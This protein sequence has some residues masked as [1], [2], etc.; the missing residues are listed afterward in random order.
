MIASSSVA[1]LTNGVVGPAVRSGSV[2]GK[3]VAFT[4]DGRDDG[5]KPVGDGQYRI[6]VWA[7]DV[8]NNRASIAK[9]VISESRAF[10]EIGRFYLKEVIGRGIPMF[11][12]TAARAS[13]PAPS[14][15]RQFLSRAFH[16]GSDQRFYDALDGN[17]SVVRCLRQWRID[18]RHAAERI[19]RRRR[20]IDAGWS[21]VASARILGFLYYSTKALGYVTSRHATA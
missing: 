4:W 13:H 15:A 1:R 12:Q 2:I 5:G 17:S 10:P 8:S 21:S 3:T 18:L 6:T 11:E 14:G 20:D 7:A 19:A 9:V 16:A